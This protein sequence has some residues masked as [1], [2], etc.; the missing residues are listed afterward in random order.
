[1][2]PVGRGEESPVLVLAGGLSAEREVSLRSGE[3]LAALLADEAVPVDVL[4][5]EPDVLGQIERASPA[6]VWPTLHGASGEDGSLA[7]VLRLTG[8]RVVGTGPDGS[9][10]SW[11]K[12]VAA[13]VAGTAGVP[14]PD[15]VT[16][17]V[18]LVRDMGAHRLLSPITARLGLPLVVKPKRGGSGFGVTRVDVEGDLPAAVVSALGHDSACRIERCVEGRE[19]TVTV[20]DPG[21]GPIACPPVE[22]EPVAGR[23]DFSARYTAGAIRFHVPARVDAATAARLA[24]HA[25]AVHRTL[26]LGMLSRSDWIVEGPGAVWFLEV[27]TS[28]GMTETSSAPLGIEAGGDL[29]GTV[30]A[31]AAAAHPL[32]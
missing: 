20:V 18:D 25:V 15:S 32:R 27:G 17:G 7:E 30:A 16:V 31:L 1:V 26:R 24:D 22:V 2:T 10:L 29:S 4:D 9:R 11:D 12:A 13:A 5:A 28:P 14:V 19:V 6:V 8:V 3:R 21:T 23:Y